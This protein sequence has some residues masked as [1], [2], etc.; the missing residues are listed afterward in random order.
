MLTVDT[1]LEKLEEAKKKGKGKWPV[2]LLEVKDGIS[3]ASD[4][5]IDN[6]PDPADGKNI[7]IWTTEEYAPKW[8]K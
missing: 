1:M 2:R 6:D 3:V 7:W 4:L 8:K 5:G